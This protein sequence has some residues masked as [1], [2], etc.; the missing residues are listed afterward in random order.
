MGERQNT[1]VCTFDPHSP[2]ISAYEIHEWI[3]AKLH[4]VEDTVTM[5]QI[6]GPRRQVY[7]NFVDKQH[8][9]GILQSTKGQSEYKHSNGEISQIRIDM[10]GMGKKQVRIAHLPPEMNERELRSALALY[11]EI[12]EI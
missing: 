9:Y 7:I 11:G 5:K 2:R 12:Q 3:H 1:L 4:V 10:T 8:V 6:D